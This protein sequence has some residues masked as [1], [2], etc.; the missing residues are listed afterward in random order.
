MQQNTDENEE[1]AGPFSSLRKTQGAESV[2]SRR[3]ARLRVS[4][5]PAHQAVL[6]ASGN[7]LDAKTS[8]EIVEPITRR[9]GERDITVVVKYSVGRDRPALSGPHHRRRK[10]RS[11]DDPRARVRST[12]IPW[13]RGIWR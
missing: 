10:A 9:A 8:V 7:S 1:I 3:I 5:W 11:F 2:A 12:L 13:R 4:H 6:P